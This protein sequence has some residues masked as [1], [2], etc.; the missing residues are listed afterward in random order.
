V[1]RGAHSQAGA[2]NVTDYYNNTLSLIRSF[3]STITK[4]LEFVMADAML[5]SPDQSRGKTLF[6]LKKKRSK[7]QSV[8]TAHG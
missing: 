5:H 8:A 1:R 6:F 3:P 4:E 2:H 7:Q